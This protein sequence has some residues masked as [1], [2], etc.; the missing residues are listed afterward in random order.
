M[1]PRWR[2]RRSPF[3]FSFNHLVGAGEKGWWDRDPK[4]FCDRQADGKPR[5]ERADLPRRVTLRKA[6]DKLTCRAVSD[7]CPFLIRQIG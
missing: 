7:Q 2:S 1:S 4:P 6:G 3:A 5:N